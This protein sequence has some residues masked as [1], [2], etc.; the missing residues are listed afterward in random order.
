[1]QSSTRPVVLLVLDGWGYRED[2][3]YNAIAHANTPVWDRLWDEYPH[4]L[5]YASEKAVGL[6]AD[7]M[8]NSEVGHLN[9]GAGRIVHQETSRIINAIE[10]GE[11]FKNKVL[12]ENLKTT[13]KAGKAVHIIG[14]LSDGG[15]HSH[16]EHIESMVKMAAAKGAEK[17][18]VHIFTDGRDTAP[19][20]A[21][22][23]INSLEASLEKIGKG[24]IASVIGRFFA[25]DRDNR[26]ERVEEAYK[27]I[28]NGESQFQ[29]DSA[30]NAIDAAYERGEKD[31][32]I[33]STAIVPQGQDKVVMEEGDMAIFMNFRSDR[34]RQITRA[35][36]ED[37]F[38]EFERGPRV[39][40]HNFVTLTRYSAD[41]DCPVAFSPEPLHNVF[42]EYISNIGLKQLRIAETEKY[43]HV[44]FFLNGGREEPFDGEDRILVPS[45]KVD[46]YDQ[47]PEMNA[48]EVTE[49]LV[50]AINSAKYDV[51][52][53]N[54]ANPDMVGHTGNFDATVKAIEALD[55]CVGNVVA[56]AQAVG[57]EVLITADHGNAELMQND[58]TG[59]AHTAHTTNCVPFLY[60]G[61][62]NATMM[63]EGALSD[64]TPTML[65][66][67]DQDKPAEMTGVSLVNFSE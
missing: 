47:Q 8:G 13:A 10:N 23:Y 27:L 43:A 61:R 59:Q 51:I 1:M 63:A 7:Q 34:A 14:L 35:F 17:L 56:A 21:H 16:N 3:T 12:C 19:K 62:K 44:T 20:S 36:I 30:V 53:C 65:Y 38:N 6:P 66:L 22:Q 55:S 60:V 57:G 45:P 26:W 28:A 15:V 18:Y 40:L 48:P 4:T 31:E 32:F 33:K 25:M 24:R 29:S 50:A 9:L 37:D 11:F 39:P 41:F 58:T 46:T 49:K 42:G 2:P 52:I 5:I 67:M 54:F 64:V